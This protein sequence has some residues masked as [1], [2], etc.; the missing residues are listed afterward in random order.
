[1]TR[2]DSDAATGSGP[3]SV[4]SRYVSSTSRRAPDRSTRR[5]ISSRVAASRAAPVGL[6][7]TVMLT[8]RVS[9]RIAADRRSGSIAQ[10]DSNVRSTMPMSAATARGVSK[11]VE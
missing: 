11:L 5:T 8:S 3:S 9:G 10:S 4:I 2:S 6:W 1:M 7:G